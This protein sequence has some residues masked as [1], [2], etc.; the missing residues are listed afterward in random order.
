MLTV[1]LLRFHNKM[2]WQ[3]HKRNTPWLVGMILLAVVYGVL[4]FNLHTFTNNLRLDGIIG[5]VLGL[6]ICSHPA[7][8]IVDLILFGRYTLRQGLSL[9]GFVLWGGLNLLVMLAGLAV[10]VTGT[11]RFIVPAQ[12]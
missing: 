9:R 5:I 12:L 1:L 4:L 11:T 6:Y 3:R 7:A 2:S 8:N 10:I